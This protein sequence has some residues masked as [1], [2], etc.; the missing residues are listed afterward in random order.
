MTIIILNWRCIKNPKEGGAERVTFRYARYWVKKGYKVIWVTSRFKNSKK[1]ECIKGV[2]FV[3]VGFNLNTGL[4]FFIFRYPLYLIL[5]WWYL[6]KNVFK[7]T[8]V[9]LV[10]DEIHG[11][12]HLASFLKNKRVVLLVCEVAG[13][14][15]WNKMFRYPFNILGFQLERLIYYF[16]KKREIWAIS[17]STKSDIKQI[18]PSLNVS[19]LPLGVEPLGANKPK[20]LPKSK[21]PSAIFVAR[22]VKMK[23]VE[24]AIKAT[25][26]ITKIHPNFILN[27][28]GSGDI[29]YVKTL[30]KMCVTLKIKNNVKFFGYVTERQKYQLMAKSY[31]L[32]HPSFKEGFGLTVLEAG[33]VK[34]PSIVREGSSLNELV[35]NGKNGYI[36]SNHKDIAKKFIQSYNKPN[37]YKLL[38][39]N[40]YVNAQKYFWSN[41]LKKSKS[42][43]KI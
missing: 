3:R 20:E 9:S 33:L 4:L 32:F 42:I 31:F 16:Y 22:L 10:V 43:T 30:K 37:T 1:T 6:I 21:F 28:V 36:I 14:D 5:V 19:I 34:T 29:N 27:I 40:A 13:K 26:I 12:P 41:I 7:N 25:K 24:D 15:I 39:T 11:F 23:G 2:N 8:E 35:I 38:S 17:K 18:N